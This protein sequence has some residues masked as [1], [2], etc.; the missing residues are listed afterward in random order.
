MSKIKIFSFL[1]A[2]TDI[3]SATSKNTYVY[4]AFIKRHKSQ[5][6]VKKS[7]FHRQSYLPSNDPTMFLRND[8]FRPCTAFEFIV[9]FVSLLL[10]ANLK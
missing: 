1:K 6:E 10:A 7:E 2:F 9:G 5:S 3:S 4:G 8:L